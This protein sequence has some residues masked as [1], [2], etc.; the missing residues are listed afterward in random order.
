[1]ACDSYGKPFVTSGVLID[2]SDSMIVMGLPGTEYQLHLRI[3]QAV[4]AA[5][6]DRVC[7][8]IHARARRID[9]APSGGRYIEP[10]YGRP[11]RIQ[12]RTA[13]TDPQSHTITVDCGCLIRC[14]LTADQ[15][16]SDFNVGDLVTFDVE[17]GA[18][19]APIQ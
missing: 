4:P 5:H 6:G 19:F 10:I 18:R 14:E 15:K 11:R 8:Q 7:G 1:M 13:A 9:K 12:G 16:P 17:R 2:R 3:S